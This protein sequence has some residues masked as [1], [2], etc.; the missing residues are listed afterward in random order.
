MSALETVINI[1]KKAEHI[2]GNEY[3]AQGRGLHEKISSVER[4]LPQP[5]VKKLRY[6]ATIRN[7]FVH[8]L[9]FELEQPEVFF[10]TANGIIA[11]LESLPK[12]SFTTRGATQS[13]GSGS[14]IL[15][16]VMFLVR[17]LKKQFKFFIIFFAVIFS[18]VVVKDV[19][20]KDK[21]KLMSKESIDQNKPLSN[22]QIEEIKWRKQLSEKV[23]KEEEAK[24]TVAAAP[25]KSLTASTQHQ[26]NVVPLT[27]NE[28]QPSVTQTD[29][30]VPVVK[31][32]PELQSWQKEM[33]QGSNIV[34]PNSLLEFSN[35]R[36]SYVKGSFNRTEPRIE[37]TVKN[38]SGRLL[39]NARLDARLYITGRSQP[40][41]DTER[42]RDSLFLSFGEMGLKPGQ[43]VQERIYISGFDKDDWV[44]PDILNAA[45]KQL[46][47]KIKS[48]DDGMGNKLAIH[49][50]GFNQ[51]DVRSGLPSPVSNKKQTV[52]KS[53][54]INQLKQDFLKG[55]SIGIGNDV[56]FVDSVVLDYKS[57][58]FGRQEAKI[59]V[60]VTNQ[61]DQFISSAYFHAQLF[62]DGGHNPVISTGRD[63]LFASFGEKG[64]APGA[65]VT[66][67]IYISGFDKRK[68]TKPAI[69]NSR[70]R[71]VVLR[72]ESVRDGS[73]R[74]MQ[75]AS[76]AHI[77]FR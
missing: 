5:L 19:L 40:I 54:E 9:G 58:A 56:L 55:K 23:K 13:N 50:V 45:R 52:S 61:T 36:F 57:G 4:K 15:A 33:A 24:K 16:L 29:A 18:V 12:D 75:S 41:L 34:V 53:P 60:T 69:M 22:R 48:I 21:E 14:L 59:K 31:K 11:D 20:V 51:L 8:E 44:S 66:D 38:T 10:H 26:P 39:S 74:E 6:V 65:T 76:A 70:N 62:L 43:T 47:L 7:N 1:S 64:L 72:I 71:Q 3:G 2:L 68:W 35:L 25:S 49:S 77:S 46:V 63:K 28:V 27:S 17:L 37:F 42:M 67:T 30:V 32:S 73:K